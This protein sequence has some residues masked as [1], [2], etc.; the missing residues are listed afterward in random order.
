M[1]APR[2]AFQKT[3]SELIAGRSGA[4]IAALFLLALLLFGFLFRGGVCVLTE[5]DRHRAEHERQAEHEAH[6]SF[7][8][9]ACLLMGL[10]N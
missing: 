8:D 7:H 4:A 5:R 1:N 9:I 3:Q 2:A 10:G 6:D